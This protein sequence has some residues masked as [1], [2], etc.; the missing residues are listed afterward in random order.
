MCGAGQAH[1][2]RCHPRD[3]EPVALVEEFQRPNFGTLQINITVDD[4]KAYTAPWK[5]KLTQPLVADTELLDYI[6]L[7]N[8][9]DQKHFVCR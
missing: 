7:E 3:V 2:G 6:C 8:E 9:K 5:V 1:G 4:P